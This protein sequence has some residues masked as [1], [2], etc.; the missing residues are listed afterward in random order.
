[1][2]A[3]LRAADHC[4]HEIFQ[5]LQDITNCTDEHTLLFYQN[6][7]KEL[8]E[9]LAMSYM[10]YGRELEGN[11]RFDEAID[12]YS[13]A[14]KALENTPETSD[15]LYNQIGKL[16]GLC[17]VKRIES[18]DKQKNKQV[19][20]AD[21]DLEFFA[22][23]GIEGSSASQLNIGKAVRITKQQQPAYTGRLLLPSHCEP[24]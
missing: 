20:L 16:R 21:S 15:R 2:K 3:S 14:I 13:K 6:K 9:R 18:I 17:I 23:P 10:T 12:V 22:R 11:S 4:E 8:A 19:S 1:M 24:F 7:R 5:L